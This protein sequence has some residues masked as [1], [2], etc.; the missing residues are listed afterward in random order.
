[1]RLAKLPD[2][3]SMKT[4]LKKSIGD[5]LQPA[6]FDRKGQSWYLAGAD[7]IVVF[8]LQKSDYDEVYY[9]NLGFWL[10]QL[11]DATFIANRHWRAI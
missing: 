6:G 8:N 9:V 11:G 4:T 7:A 2:T 1:M 3:L 5:V 10:K